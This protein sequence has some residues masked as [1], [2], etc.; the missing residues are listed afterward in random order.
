MMTQLDVL[1]RKADK[2]VIRHWNGLAERNLGWAMVGVV[3]PTDL[4]EHIIAAATG[5]KPIPLSPFERVGG[6]VFTVGNAPD[7]ATSVSWPVERDNAAA[8]RASFF[9]S[10]RRK[11]AVL[12]AAGKTTDAILLLRSKGL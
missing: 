5:E 7:F 8:A 10:I 2:A 4:G 9:A 3:R 1:I 6:P 11:S 12:E